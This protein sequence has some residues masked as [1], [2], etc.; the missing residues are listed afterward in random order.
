MKEKGLKESNR[1]KSLDEYIKQKRKER[2]GFFKSKF[3]QN[4]NKSSKSNR[5]A[6]NS[7]A[8]AAI[9]NPCTQSAISCF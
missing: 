6:S 3:L 5:K 8:E 1:P 7:R 9:N 2:G 4:A